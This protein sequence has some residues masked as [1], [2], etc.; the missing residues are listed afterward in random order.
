MITFPSLLFAILIASL[1]G[2]LYHFFRD[3][4]PGKLFLYIL[5]SWIGFGFGHGLGTW[6]RVQFLTVGALHLGFS[7]L[8]SFLII[9]L[10]DWISTIAKQPT[11]HLPDDENGV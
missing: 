4:G 10:G 7:T 1:Y 8:G 9:I 2:A 3:G 6:L 5:F 11:V